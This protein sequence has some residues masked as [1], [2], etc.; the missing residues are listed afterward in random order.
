MNLRK[1]HY[2]TDPRSSI[3]ESGPWPS[4]VTTNAAAMLRGLGGWID[5]NYCPSF[6]Q[7]NWHWPKN[8]NQRG[9]VPRV[10]SFVFASAAA[11]H[12]TTYNFQQRMSRFPQRWRTQR[13][14]IRNANCKTSWIIKILNAH[15]AFG[16]FPVACLSECLWIPLSIGI[17][18]YYMIL[19]AGYFGSDCSS[20]SLCLSSTFIVRA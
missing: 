15:C 17:I 3:R 10:C 2:H 7:R 19:I 12:L 8:L 9:S 20:S 16:I 18:F 14:A 13:N 5:Y 11:P 4:P 6:F 1:D